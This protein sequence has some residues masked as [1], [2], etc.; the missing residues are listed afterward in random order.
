MMTEERLDK[1]F[2]GFVDKVDNAVDDAMDQIAEEGEQMVKEF[3]DTRGTGRTWS[4][5]YYKAGKP[6]RASRPGRVWT[7]D[8]RKDIEGESD[9]LSNET[10]RASFGWINNY[11]EYYGLQE[12]GF[13]HPQTGEVE[14]MFAMHDAADLMAKRAES[15]LSTKIREVK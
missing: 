1:W 12:G 9:R 11:E 3:I 6:R 14:G 5:T 8:M 4:R 10:A 7:G 13:E 2:V 15:I